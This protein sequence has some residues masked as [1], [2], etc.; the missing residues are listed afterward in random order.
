VALHV[1][2]RASRTQWAGIHGGAAL[3]LRLQAPPVDGKANEEL[4]RFL[5]D[6]FGVPRS[7]VSILSGQSG[8]DKC[9]LIAGAAPEDIVERLSRGGAIP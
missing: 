6:Y 7:A 3:K 4:I 5:A 8:R 1:Q 9:V 2:P